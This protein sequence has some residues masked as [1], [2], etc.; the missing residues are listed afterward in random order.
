MNCSDGM[1]CFD[2]LFKLPTGTS[3]RSRSNVQHIVIDSDPVDLDDDDDD[4]DDDYE[5]L[6]SK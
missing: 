6:N 3:K 1:N 4:D 2:G 5:Q